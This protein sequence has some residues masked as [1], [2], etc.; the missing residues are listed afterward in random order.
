MSGHSEMHPDWS[1][2]LPYMEHSHDF[3]SAWRRTSEYLCEART[4]LSEAAEGVCEDEIVQFE[5]FLGHNE[6]ELALDAIEA[7]F[8]KG[9]DGNWRVLELMAK[10]ALSMQLVER[11]RQYDEW[12]TLARGWTYKTSLSR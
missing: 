6:L 10:A 9:D 7:A 2:A 11:Q 5:E 1:A 12:L 4:N 3:N 8:K